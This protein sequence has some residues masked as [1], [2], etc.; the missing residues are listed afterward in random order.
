MNLIAWIR[1][2]CGDAEIDAHCRR[3]PQNHNIRLF[4]KGISHLN[5]VTGAEHDQIS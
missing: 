5:R 2:A 4:M 1:V 3:L